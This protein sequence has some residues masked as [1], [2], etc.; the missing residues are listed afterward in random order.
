MS[1][2]IP[3]DLRDFILRH[4]DSIAELEALL[5]LRANP[6]EEWT[7][8]ATSARLYAGEAEVAKVL[9]RLSEDGFLTCANDIYRYQCRDAE[10][11]RQVDRLAE[12]Y[13]KHLIP[14]TNMIHAKLRRIREFADAFRFRKDR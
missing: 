14:V 2:L 3:D 9:A 8:A 6:K 1:E 5:L 10:L 13:A 12:A 7:V 4:F 11:Q